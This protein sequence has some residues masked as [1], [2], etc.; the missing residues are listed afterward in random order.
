[1]R[2]R[3]ARARSL[4]RWNIRPPSAKFSTSSLV[5]P[6]MSNPC[7]TPSPRIAQRLC[8]AE[9]AYVMRLEDDGRYHPAAG[10]DVEPARVEF[11]RQNP[12]APDRGSTTGR[13]ALEKRT[14]HI[15]DALADPEYTLPMAGHSG[16]R[17]LLGV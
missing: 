8:H 2:C 14:I 7:S 15:V 4:N 11:L 13:V 6:R 5:R 12:I 9:Q 16:Y 10:K 1:M 3:R 17:T